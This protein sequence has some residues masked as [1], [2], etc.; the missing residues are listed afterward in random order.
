MIPFPA[1]MVGGHLTIAVAD[2]VPDLNFEPICRDAAGEQLG[3]K[4]NFAICLQGEKNARNQLAAHWGEF[5]VADRA[6]CIRVSTLDRAGSYIEVL[7]CLELERDAKQ[8]RRTTH[9][10]PPQ[11]SIA[12]EAPARASPPAPEIA[13]PPA[14]GVRASPS[15]VSAAPAALPPP[16]SLEPQGGAA[17]GLLQIL[18]VPG[19]KSILPACIPSGG[20]P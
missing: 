17:T 13:G 15:A 4:D 6:R 2:R 7:T 8:L 3:I 1:L 14:A 12:I 20:R 11:T 18:C 5:D 16:M 10:T 19:L 9:Q